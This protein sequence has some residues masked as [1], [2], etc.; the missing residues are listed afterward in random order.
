MLTATEKQI[1]RTKL[2]KYEGKV[3][4]MYLD[5]KGYVT[6]GVG[7]LINSV[8]DAQK[9]AFI[10]PKSLP[11]SATDI[12]ADYDTVKKQP[13]NRLASFYKKH[14]KLTLPNAEVDKLTNKHIDSFEKEL[15]LIYSGFD[16]FPSEVKLALFDLI[17]NLGMPNLKNKWPMFNAA[18]KAKDW[19]K[20][21]YNSS[22]TAPISAERNKYVK[23][24]LEKAAKTAQSRNPKI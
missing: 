20:A 18:I 16:A 15:R 8:A 19:Q 6:V 13:A 14:A 11:A 24:L 9:L 17:F 10:T 5:S 12:K 23:D 4:Y 3:N 22:R 21:A 2:E 1:L 7:H